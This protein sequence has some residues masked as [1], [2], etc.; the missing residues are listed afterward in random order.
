MLSLLLNHFPKLGVLR[1]LQSDQ[2]GTRNDF[3]LTKEFRSVTSI[4]RAKRK[5]PPAALSTVST[6]TIPPIAPCRLGLL[7]L[8]L[9]GFPLVEL[10]EC[11]V[12]VEGGAGVFGADGERWGGRDDNDGP[13]GKVV[14]GVGFEGEGF[15]E[16]PRE[17]GRYREEPLLGVCGGGVDTS[18]SGA[19]VVRRGGGPPSEAKASVIIRNEPSKVSAYRG[20]ESQ[21]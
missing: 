13:G 12:R 2:R 11:I 14:E 6:S 21:S 3:P 20:N 4:S 19:E 5:S 15:T 9:I 7:G 1:V 17:G 18:R 10:G 16:D 8:A